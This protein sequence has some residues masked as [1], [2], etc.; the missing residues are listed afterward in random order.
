MLRIVKIQPKTFGNCRVELVVLGMLPRWELQRGHF[1]L[2]SCCWCPS[3]MFRWEIGPKFVPTMC[4]VIISSKV[5]W[6]DGGGGGFP[7]Q[8][9]RPTKI[10]G[11][12]D[13]RIY[14]V[15]ATKTSFATIAITVWKMQQKTPQFNTSCKCFLLVKYNTPYSQ[16]SLPP[17]APPNGNVW[18][19]YTAK[20]Q[21]Q[22]CIY[23][24][25]NSLS[26]QRRY[27]LHQTGKPLVTMTSLCLDHLQGNIWQPQLNTQCV[28]MLLKQNKNKTNNSYMI[29]V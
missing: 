27:H 20:M 13:C 6:C 14:S 26:S 16:Y 17:P 15:F 1:R 2:L 29:S 3:K 11:K 21:F 5:L 12:I 8:N 22:T 24:D 25:W 9:P 7:T 19:R 18:L 4:F 28:L 23:L 10:K